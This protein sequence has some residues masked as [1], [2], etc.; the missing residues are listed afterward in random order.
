MALRTQER[1]RVKNG[2]LGSDQ[3]FGANGYFLVPTRDGR[4]TLSVIISNGELWEH[5]SVSLKSRT[6]TWEEMEYIKRLFWEDNDT[7]IQLHPPIS[8]YINKCE[9]CLHM[10]RKIGGVVELPPSFMVA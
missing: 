9:N 7:V 6:P 10:W 5:V 1:Y 8:Q 4:C 2:Q 3:S